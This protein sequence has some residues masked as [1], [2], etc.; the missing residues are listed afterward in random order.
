MASG[1][2]DAYAALDMLARHPRIDADRI[3]I[4][5]FS[6]GGEVAH[7]TAFERRAHRV[8]AP[9]QRRFAAHVAYYP[10]GQLR[11]RGRARG[12]YRRADPAAAGREGRQPARGEGDG[13]SRLRPRRGISGADR[14]FSPIRALITPGRFPPSVRARFYPQYRQHAKM[15]AH[16]VWRAAGRASLS[17][18]RK[19]RSTSMPWSAA[20][21]RVGATP[22][23]SMR[24]SGPSPPPTRWPFFGSTCR[25]EPVLPRQWASPRRGAPSLSK[26]RS[27]ALSC[28]RRRSAPGARRDVSHADH[29]AQSADL[30]AHPRDPAG[31]RT[32]YVPAPTRRRGSAA[33]C[34]RLAGFTDWLDGHWRGVWQQQS[35]LGRFLDPIADKLLVAATLFMLAATGRLSALARS[36]RRW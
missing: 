25:P 19:R 15:S 12:L 36:C 17:T 6:F 22:W 7:L 3:A 31:R 32:F 23:R 24:R 28:R 16:P 35:E 9:G 34:S 5:G 11:R 26:P 1:V 18:A 20:G 29:P 21:R 14:R 27:K 8:L 2:A 30:V 13:V 4:V 33:S 10:G